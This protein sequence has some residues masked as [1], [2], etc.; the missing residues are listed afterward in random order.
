MVKQ[1][2]ASAVVGALDVM[3]VGGSTGLG[4]GSWSQSCWATMG[5]ALYLSG[6]NFP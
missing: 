3:G 5:K 6:L 1:F 4:L 2:D